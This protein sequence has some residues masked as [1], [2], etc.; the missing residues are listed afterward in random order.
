VF[1]Y[2]LANQT[3]NSSASTGRWSRTG[4]LAMKLRAAGDVRYRVH[5]SKS[6]ACELVL[7]TG[8]DVHD[9]GAPSVVLAVVRAVHH[10]AISDVADE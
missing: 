9:R 6:S 5:C 2:P 7:G 4:S 10:G 1:K 3:A 8:A